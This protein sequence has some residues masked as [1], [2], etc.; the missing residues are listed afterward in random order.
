MRTYCP[1]RAVIRVGT[2]RTV[3]PDAG[4]VRTGANNVLDF[5]IPMADPLQIGTV[6]YGAYDEETGV[7]AFSATIAGNRLNLVLP[8]GKPGPM[9]AFQG[10]DFLTSADITAMCV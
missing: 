5:D 7:P 3:A 1:R 6:S 4:D 8:Q 10:A 9:G 2:V